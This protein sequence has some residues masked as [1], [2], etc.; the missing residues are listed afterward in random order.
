MDSR[1]QMRD[2]RLDPNHTFTCLHLDFLTGHVT[3]GGLPELIHLGVAKC[4]NSQSL[5]NL[6]VSD[7]SVSCENLE[8][9]RLILADRYRFERS[10]STFDR[11]GG[12]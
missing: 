8:G 2:T 12:S 5:E 4:V 10:L 1:L 3:L 11:L 7:P 9:S 6:P